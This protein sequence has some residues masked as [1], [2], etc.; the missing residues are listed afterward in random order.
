MKKKEFEIINDYFKIIISKLESIHSDEN[1]RV[2]YCI[3]CKKPYLNNRNI[4][5]YYC[6]E[7]SKKIK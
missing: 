5:L 4:T 6:K 1:T 3:K 7:C 2:G